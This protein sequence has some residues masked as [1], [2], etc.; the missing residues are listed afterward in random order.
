VEQV[1]SSVPPYCLY[2]EGVSSMQLIS[3]NLGHERAMQNGKPSG[4]TGIY[5]LPTS[6]VVQVTSEG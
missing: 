3:V 5:K 4:K 1:L 2:K 6:D